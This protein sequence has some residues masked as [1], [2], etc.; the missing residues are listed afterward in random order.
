MSVSSASDN[1][2]S[3]V[4]D[5]GNPFGQALMTD[6]GRILDTELPDELQKSYLSV[7]P[8]DHV[9]HSA[10]TSVAARGNAG[11]LSNQQHERRPIGHQCSS[12]W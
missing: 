6:T 9:V 11:L 7:S 4:A 3:A 8:F 10:C 1:G 2:A 12:S 5:A